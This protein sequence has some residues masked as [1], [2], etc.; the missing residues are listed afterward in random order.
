MSLSRGEI[1]GFLR[2]QVTLGKTE[3]EAKKAVVDWMIKQS[4]AIV[5]KQEREKIESDLGSYKV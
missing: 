5:T 1:M 3:E 2:G 4:A